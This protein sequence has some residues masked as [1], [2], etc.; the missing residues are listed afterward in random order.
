MSLLSGIGD[1]FSAL[2]GAVTRFLSTLFQTE[3]QVVDNV[4]AIVKGFELIKANTTKEIEK[5]RQ[6]E[7]DPHW[8]SRVINVPTAIDQTRDFIQLVVSKFQD[9]FQKIAQPIKDFDKVFASE[10]APDPLGDKPS[11]LSKTAVKIGHIA[12]MIAE[13]RKAVDAIEDVSELFNDIT[14]KL[15]GLDTLFLSQ[16]RS[17]VRFT[18]TIRQRQR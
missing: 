3:L 2:F 1:F 17:Q 8:K 5:L 10:A 12:E 16:G 11:A 18:K 4:Q 15:K 9:D 6:F 14:D 13:I 7:F